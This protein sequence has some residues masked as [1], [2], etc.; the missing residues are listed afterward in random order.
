[1]GW[2]LEAIAVGASVANKFAV[3]APTSH[4]RQWS[5]ASFKISDEERRFPSHQ[6]EDQK[7]KVSGLAPH[8]LYR[9]GKLK[10]PLETHAWDSARHTKRL[11]LFSIQAMQRPTHCEWGPSPYIQNIDPPSVVRQQGGQVV[12]P[13]ISRRMRGPC[14]STK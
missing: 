4:H 2:W 9:R 3:I 13:T 11:G 12:K 14:S 8:F 6:V 5:G 10:W 1:M 7:S